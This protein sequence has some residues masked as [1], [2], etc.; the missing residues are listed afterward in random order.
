MLP[1]V[2]RFKIRRQKGRGL[3]LWFPVIIIWVLLAA[4]LVL[5]LP[6]VLLAAILTWRTG[7]GRLLLLVYPLTANVLA[8]LSGLHVEIAGGA[9]E[10]LVDFQ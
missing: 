2:M 1:V 9:D 6:F 8:N 7:P 4:L 10:I 3:G 5:V